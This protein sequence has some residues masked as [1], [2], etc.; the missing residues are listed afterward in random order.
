MKRIGIICTIVLC[1]FCAAPAHSIVWVVDDDG[2]PGVDFTAIQDCLYAA[3]TG[4]PCQVRAGTYVENLTWPSTSGITL[5]GD[6]PTT[7]VVDGNGADPVI[8]VYP[9]VVGADLSI[10]GLGIRNG[11]GSGLGLALV[12]G[13]V[14]Q[15]DGL[16]HVHSVCGEGCCF[17]ISLPVEGHPRARLDDPS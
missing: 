4:D 13:I 12:Q 17:T 15:H 7:C 16:I 2:G 3:G 6:D 11:G 9:Y 14:R 10:R 8:N 5:A 1:M